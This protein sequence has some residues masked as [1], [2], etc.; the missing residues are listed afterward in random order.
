M[1]KVNNIFKQMLLQISGLLLLQRSLQMCTAHVSLSPANQTHESTCC[2]LS[3]LLMLPRC[4]KNVVLIKQILNVKRAFQLHFAGSLHSSKFEKPSSSL[5]NK[6]LNGLQ[7]TRDQTTKRCE[8]TWEPTTTL[9][10]LGQSIQVGGGCLIIFYCYEVPSIYILCLIFVTTCVQD[11]APG[12]FLSLWLSKPPDA[13]ESV[14]QQ[15]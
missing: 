12:Q 10:W 14:E 5:K 2:W 1:K 13:S 6:H 8:Q 15:H 4:F 3:W 7:K 9:S 11:T